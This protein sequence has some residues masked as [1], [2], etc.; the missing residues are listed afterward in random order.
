[1]KFESSTLFVNTGRKAIPAMQKKKKNNKNNVVLAFCIIIIAVLCVFVGMIWR[2]WFNYN[3]DVSSKETNTKAQIEVQV[4]KEEKPKPAEKEQ[5]KKEEP[6]PVKKKTYSVKGKE[7]KLSKAVK[8]AFKDV[9]DTYSYGILNLEDGYQYIYNTD[10]IYNSA[11][12][13]AFLMEYASEAIYIGSFDYTT[14]VFGYSGS[15]L[16]NRAFSEGS[17]ESANLLIEYFGVDNLNSYLASN[18]YKDTYFANAI[19]DG[20]E[21]YTTTGDIIKLIKKMYDNTGFFPYSD[22]YSKMLSN[23]VDDKIAKTL[24]AGTRVANISFENE[25]EVFD[26]AIVYTDK[27]AFIFT[28]MAYDFYEDSLKAKAA[29]AAGAKGIY[30]AVK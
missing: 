9:D 25:E 30:N 19:G 7:N 28:A 23:T 18:G 16:M 3:E 22:M 13:G 11:A 27:S 20:S 6:K 2:A 8:K 1:M 10:K 12:L 4:E 24:P 21:S 15:H 17:I 29:I 14:D 26:A 5:P